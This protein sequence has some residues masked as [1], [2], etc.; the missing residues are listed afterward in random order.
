VLAALLHSRQTG[1]G[2]IVDAAICDGTASLMS[3]MYG[4]LSEGAWINRRSANRL[5]G[6]AHFYNVYQCADGKW[7]SIAAYEAQFYQLLRDELGLRDPEFDSQM[8]R[9]SWPAL[10]ARLAAM[11][12]QKTQAEWCAMLEGT[13]VCFAPVLDLE[14]APLHAHNVARGIFPNVDGVVQPAPA[15]RFS[16]TP[17]RIQSPPPKVGQHNASVVQDWDIAEALVREWLS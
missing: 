13:D 15:P 16:R 17:G 3:Y 6:G 7:I 4:F 5:D 2:Q 12:L 11:F 10:R 9:E 1:E 8:E 14:E